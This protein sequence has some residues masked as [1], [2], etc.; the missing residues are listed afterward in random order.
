MK[1]I[2]EGKIL[3]VPNLLS[4]LRLCLIPLFVRAYLV[5]RN[6]GLASQLLLLG[7]ATD[8]ADGMIARRFGMTSELGKLLDPAADKLTQAAVLACLAGRCPR[9]LALLGLL[10][11]KELLCA[12]TGLAAARSDGSLRS[13]AWHGKLATVLLYVLLVSHLLWT[14]MPAALSLALEAVCAAAILLS[15]ALYVGGNLRRIRRGKT[16][17][18]RAG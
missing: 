16:G 17:K 2:F 14:A 11:V 18:D 12:A 15:G 6:A 5:D 8:V 7:G 4:L 13:A 9:L 10:A 1:S 3:T